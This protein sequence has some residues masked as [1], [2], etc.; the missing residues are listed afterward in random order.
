MAHE[1]ERKFLVR[2]DAWRSAVTDARE[3]RQ[4]YL[5]VDPART[6]RVRVAGRAAT[7]TIKGPRAQLTAL[8]IE[9]ELPLHDA[10]TLLDTVCLRPLVEKTRHL[11]PIDGMVWEVDV[12]AGD[13]AGLVVAE[14]EL[15]TNTTA[16]S[17]PAW[18]G[19]EVSD[20]PRYS[21]ANLVRHPFTRW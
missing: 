8:E 6:V 13:N 7:L 17:L 3:I 11:V 2:S 15:P 9:V 19:D 16:V 4:G 10:T 18:I 12:F 20:D 21:N 1:I 5:S 14:I